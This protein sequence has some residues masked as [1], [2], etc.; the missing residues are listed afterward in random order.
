MGA[1][2]LQHLADFPPEL[3][4]FIGVGINLSALFGEPQPP[5]LAAEQLHT[6]LFLKCRNLPTD[7]LRGQI[8]ALAGARDA[9]VSGNMEEIVQVVV[10]EGRHLR[11]SRIDYL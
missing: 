11:N 4:N 9:A 8:Q 3:E 5:S 2:V 7:G 6:K 1:L 10:V